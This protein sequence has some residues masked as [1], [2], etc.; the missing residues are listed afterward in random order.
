[1]QYHKDYP[2]ATRAKS[3]DTEVGHENAKA[4]FFL[5]HVELLG[6]G[7]GTRTS[8]GSLAGIASFAPTD[9]ANEHVIEVGPAGDTYENVRNRA[10]AAPGSLIND[11]TGAPLPPDA[12]IAAGTR[13]R[14]A[15]IRWISAV[16]NETLG[17]VAQQHHVSLEAIALANNMSGSPASTPLVAGTRILIPIHQSPV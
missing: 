11:S 1:M 8:R 3:I 17:S 14:I 13:V 6:I 5:G 4:A 12:P 2:E 15:G 9:E 7:A 16:G 10:G